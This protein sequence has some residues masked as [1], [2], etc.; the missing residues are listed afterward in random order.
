MRQPRSMFALLIPTLFLSGCS[1]PQS[2]APANAEADRAAIDRGHEAF[3]AA[4]RANDCNALLLLLTPDV[5]FAPPNVPTA[6]G[7]DGVRAWCEPI[8]KQVKTTT[9]AVSG[10]DVDIAGDWAIE[11]GVFDWTVVPLAGGPE[12]RDQGRFLAIYHRQPDG[13][14][15]LARDVWNSS[16][17]LPSAAPK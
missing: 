17:P 7:Q 4:M 15:K 5:V 12:Q 16:L 2:S 3:L 11:H 10:R 1:K 6:T 8:F 9:V 13:S 14:W